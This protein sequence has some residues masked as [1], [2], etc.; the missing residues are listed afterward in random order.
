MRAVVLWLVALLLAG[1]GGGDDVKIP[2]PDVP[3]TIEVTSPAFFDGRPI[4]E[5]HTCHGAGTSPA[6]RWEGVPD[7]AASLALVVWDP[8]APRGA[9]LH[10]LVYD[11]TPGDGGVAAGRVPDGA[12]GG[13][14]RE[15]ENSA[16]RS[17]WFP[18]CPP[19][20]THRYVF[21]VYAL[22]ASVRGRDSQHVLDDVA[23]HAIAT[24]SLM[25][26]VSAG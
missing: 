21:T 19:S 5:R 18:P 6:L 8:D 7:G 11:V 9:F 16:R 26:T 15:G 2:Q 20:G 13:E 22:D 10:W 14:A 23:R 17:G 24:G 4:P 3:A 1:C 25:G 12:G